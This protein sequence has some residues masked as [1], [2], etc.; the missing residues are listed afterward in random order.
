M[1]DTTINLDNLVEQFKE[2]LKQNITNDFNAMW[3]TQEID[4]SLSILQKLSDK[5]KE[6]TGW[7]ILNLSF[8]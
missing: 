8:N 3:K 2:K 1:N 7:L 4:E 5:T 6:E